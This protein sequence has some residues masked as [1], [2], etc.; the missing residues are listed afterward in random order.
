[1]SDSFGTVLLRVLLLMQLLPFFVT[2]LVVRG[3]YYLDEKERRTVV[4]W[5]VPIGLAANLVLGLMAHF[6]LFRGHASFLQLIMADCAYQDFTRLAVQ[7][8]I[9]TFLAAV[10]GYLGVGIYF[11][12]D[13]EDLYLNRKTQSRL[14]LIL[15]AALI[16]VLLGLSFA[17]GGS[18]QIKITE[19]CRKTTHTEVNPYSGEISQT[20]GSFVVLT[21]QSVTFSQDDLTFYLSEDDRN[22]KNQQLQIA[23][24]SPGE[25]ETFFLNEDES[26]NVK[27]GGGS[28][29]VLSDSIGKPLYSVDIPALKRDEVY[30]LGNGGWEITELEAA[31]GTAA[32]VAPPVFSVPAGFYEEQF[33]LELHSEPG[34]TIYYT[35][36][37]SDPTADSQKYEGPILIYNKSPE[38]NV[39]RAIRNVTRDYL[40]K[41][42]E[43]K[44]VLK[45]FV[46]RAVSVDAN[47]DVSPIQTATY[48]VGLPDMYKNSTVISLV[49][50]P[51][52]LFDPEYGIYV[53]GKA[54][55][56]WYKKAYTSE[57]YAENT[58][59]PVNFLQRGD[60]WERLAQFE[61]F[62]GT[63]ELVNQPVGIRIQGSSA[64]ANALKRFSIY[65]RKEYSGSN[66]F[67]KSLYGSYG[68]H[69][70]TLRE[71]FENS[72][73]QLLVADRAVDTQNS[74]PVQVFLNG[75]FWYSTYLQ[76]KYS[77]NSFSQKYNLVKNNVQVL[78]VGYM[79][80]LTAVEKE[81]YYSLMDSNV[82]ANLAD[83]EVY[84]HFQSIVDLQSYIDYTCTNLYL[85]NMDTSDKQNL[86]VWRAEIKE[87]DAQGDGRWRWALYDMDLARQDS[88]KFN[89]R[90]ESAQ[91][92][93]FSDTQPYNKAV[94][95]QQPLFVSLKN[96]PDFCKQFVLT[97]LDMTN[98]NFSPER[99][100][101][102][103][104]AWGRNIE[105]YD[106]GF[107]LKRGQYAIAHLAE[108]FALKGSAETVTVSSSEKEARIQLNTITPE[109]KELYPEEEFGQVS[110]AWSGTYFTD[111]PVTVCADQPNFVRWEVISNGEITIYTDRTIEVP[112]AKGGIEIHAIFQ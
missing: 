27:K 10:I 112:V 35:L 33:R 15:S 91:T 77:Q 26:L 39:Y 31:G 59:L 92:N 75:E 49:S 76:E 63:E 81:L 37:S 24:L 93:A 52:C 97:F 51:K 105:T 62:S 9:C 22:P 20:E 101:S 28:Y 108:E 98:Y 96:N 64:R 104:E 79:A 73:S 32:S 103:M 50:D 12:G 55:D 56:E 29:I 6:L 65:S 44:P 95:N 5:S 109:L 67:D 21:N 94:H 18:E 86:C 85:C 17:D 60:A 48:F 19:F 58:E 99:V 8:V 43:N 54:Y 68:T 1:M 83:P 34:T 90:A 80:N 40:R 78:R 100:K 88:A 7:I 3:F 87:N 25:S 61:M 106:N 107:F 13:L 36:D 66:L 57:N 2:Q 46:V 23:Y 38:P 84:Q 72:F 110:Y 41:E 53:V 82:L 42:E 30:R 111:Y 45:G 74:I 102:L 47:G 11:G 16:P 4:W 14:F 70:A 69:S 71:G 89:G